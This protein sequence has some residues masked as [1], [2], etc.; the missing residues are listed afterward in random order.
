MLVQLGEYWINS[1]HVTA[2]RESTVDESQ[3]CVWVI[4]A[5][6]VDGAFLIDLPVEDVVEAVNAVQVQT[7]AER[8]LEDVESDS[9]AAR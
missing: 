7:L 9:A 1:E 6:T 4:G 2:I 3:T 8:L 5:S